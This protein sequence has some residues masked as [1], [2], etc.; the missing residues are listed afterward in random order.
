[1]GFTMN[2]NDVLTSASIYLEDLIGHTFDILTIS[3]PKKASSAANL[4]R[5]IS[6]L[7]P[8]LGNMIEFKTVDF[9]NDQ[10]QFESFG[11]WVRQDPGFPDTIFQGSI[12]PVPGIEIKTW[13]PLSTEITARFK[14]SQ[15]Y[16]TQN[17]TY[18]CMLA[19]LPDCMIFGKPQ[20]IDVCFASCQSIAKARDNHYHN[21]PSYLVIEPEDTKGRTT[22]LRQTNTNGYKF[23]GN[24]TQYAEAE[25]LLSSW[26]ED[27]K[28]YK[29]SIG[30]KNQIE[31]LLA[32]FPYRLDTN[33]AKLDRIQ[34][35]DIEQF[36]SRV[37]RR[38]LLGK[39]IKEWHNL[40]YKGSE[41]SKQQTFEAIIK[42][43]STY[44]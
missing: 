8:F 40:M 19:W 26:G 18:V 10:P 6:K 27:A 33:F 42:N 29:P 15:R 2:T 30:Y 14:D 11:K 44:R 24:A 21:P 5:V 9:L 23:Q 38:K 25:S 16:F 39:Q 36:K 22:N 32:R 4:A 43:A 1:M 12:D 41:S 17:H 31:E 3:N 28:I 7:S 34:H 13:F 35:K 20:I 37:L